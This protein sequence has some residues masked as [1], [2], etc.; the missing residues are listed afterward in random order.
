[1]VAPATTGFPISAQNH[2]PLEQLFRSP[3]GV[4]HLDEDW[5]VERR[6][7]A[8]SD[9]H[10]PWPDETSRSRRLVAI[11]TPTAPTTLVLGS[12]QHL[13]AASSDEV[14]VVHR[15]SGGGAV[16]VA[17][18]AQVWVDVWIPRSDPLWDDD[19]VTSSFWLGE[20]WRNALM[21]LGV[22][23]LDVHEGRLVRTSL[24]D[25]VCF[26]GV[27]PGELSWKG[28]KLVGI[29]QRRNRHGARFQSVSPLEP[30]GEAMLKFFDLDPLE[31]EQMESTLSK[32]TTGLIEAAGAAEVH[33]SGLDGSGLVERVEEEFVRSITEGAR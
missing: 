2:S 21:A 16:L 27:G 23:D 1:V 14:A 3:R 29:S 19:V 17:P 12:A 18:D 20:T 8:A 30:Q 6:A 25:L 13:A 22:R 4:M 28:R 11:C 5:S 9:L 7:G 10:A 31:R 24:S 26:A 32:G 33:G 15:P